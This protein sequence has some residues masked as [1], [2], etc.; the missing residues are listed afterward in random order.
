MKNSIIPRILI[1]SVAAL[2]GASIGKVADFDQRYSAA[3]GGIIAAIAVGIGALL[4]T[5]TKELENTTPPK[6]LLGLRIGV[7]GFCVAASGCI[8]AV[9]T[10]QSAGFILAA[11]GI[12]TGFVG[13]GIH[14][15]N[16]FRK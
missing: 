2:F 1:I 15:V 16:M 11:T 6:K 12:G 5:K 8:V 13:M 3:F 9:Y 14:F 7:I 4:N 10:S